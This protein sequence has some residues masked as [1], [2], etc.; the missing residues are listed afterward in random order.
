M[1]VDAYLPTVHPEHAPYKGC[2]ANEVIRDHD[3]A[4]SYVMEHYP[5]L[6]PSY[7]G[8]APAEQK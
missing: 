8:L 6:L 3:V 4:L 5:A 1:K 2:L 7:Q